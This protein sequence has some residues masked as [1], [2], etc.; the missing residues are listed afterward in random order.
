[1]KKKMWIS[2]TLF[3]LMG[4][5]VLSGCGTNAAVQTSGAMD[6][7][8]V[9]Q[10]SDDAGA[11]EAAEKESES[12]NAQPDAESL[13]DST[14]N[15][16]LETADSVW[17]NGKI[18]TVDANNLIVEAIAVKDGKILFTGSDADVETYIGE[19][20]NV[21]D[22]EGK[23]VIPGLI[24]AHTHA[25][26]TLMS[27]MYAIPV[28]NTSDLD[29]V[30]RVVKEFV[31]SHPEMDA[32]FGRGYSSAMGDSTRGPKKEWLDEISPDKPIILQETGGHNWWM[33]SAGFALAGITKDTVPQ[34]GNIF[35]DPETG[36]LWGSVAN[37]KGIEIPKAEYTVE[38]WE[39]AVEV[40]QN[41]L[42]EMGYTT[43][44]S[45]SGEVTPNP[46]EAIHALDQ[47]GRLKLRVN[48]SLTIFPDKPIE[49]QLDYLVKKRE[50]YKSPLF[51][52][53]FAKFFADGA[54]EG[55]TANVSEPY[56]EK[57]ED[58]RDNYG[59]FYWDLETLPSVFEETMKR[60]LQVHVHSIGDE[61][62]TQTL[63]ALEKAQKAL[64]GHDYR[65]G[66]TH[67][68][69]VKT[70]DYARFNELGVTAV[71]NPFWHLKEPD[72]WEPVEKA[73]LGD[74]R[75]NQEYPAK[76]LYEAKAVI[77]CASDG[78]ST[79]DPWPMRAIEAGVTRNLND[80][81]YYGVEDIHDMDDPTCLLNA[82]ERLSVEEMVRCF[83]ING[84]YSMFRE[85]ETGSLE[86]G[87]YADFLI[88]DQDIFTIDPL[89]INETTVLYTIFNGEV[90]FSRE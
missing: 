73:V 75:A 46:I 90:V 61:A 56:V 53:S 80:P 70:E 43:I 22:L 65:N 50:E 49:E 14:R 68:Q 78:V 58:G 21:T 30:L 74:E 33:N 69:I 76:S 64:G 3:A 18:H 26:G 66:I 2:I 7:S 60:G 47:E 44:A 9:V 67:L 71:T 59:S 16:A 81:D 48:A 42:H 1:M 28:P 19:E 34:A 31:D 35:K 17:K 25:P 5:S 38:Q 63:N 37:I 4:S 83:T 52:V 57:T 15:S 51:D 72:W 6:A 13:Q 12:L 11:K 36:E 45:M 29:E 77:A 23:T 10:A 89:Q 86:T 85:K 79:P 27:E 84:A 54:V 87:K 88:L 39:T 55:A 82:G 62:T 41:Q 40:Y 20:T 8:A 24:D 32:Y